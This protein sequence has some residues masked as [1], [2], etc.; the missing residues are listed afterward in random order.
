MTRCVDVSDNKRLNQASPMAMAAFVP[1]Y[2]ILTAAM[3]LGV[4]YLICVL[5]SFVFCQLFFYYKPRYV[6]LTMRFLFTNS[7]L[8][9]SF[10]DELHIRDERQ[11]DELR[12]VLES[13]VVRDSRIKNSPR[14]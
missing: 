2:I 13:E 11:I 8:T 9:P 14:V 7:Y 5:V 10:H 1:I 4:M 3:T 12:N 6:F